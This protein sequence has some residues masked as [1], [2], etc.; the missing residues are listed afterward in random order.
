MPAG[1]PLKLPETIYDHDFAL[2]AK[3]ENHARTR[4]RLLGIHNLQKGKGLRETAE[5]LGV[6]ELSVK[7]WLNRFAKNGLEG[8]REQK[9]RGNKRKLHDDQ[10]EAFREAVLELQANRSGGR[11]RGSDVLELMR[12]K[13]GI[14]CCLD[15]AYETLKR[16]H[17]V[18]ITARS[19]H[20]EADEATQS[21]FKK[22]SKEN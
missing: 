13:L 19:Q 3:T 18:W 17:F 5:I 9:G 21:A 20:P 7:N 22:T 14:D 8:L 2:L 11:I 16:A 1:R 15:T 4:L 10:Q 12:E 6:H